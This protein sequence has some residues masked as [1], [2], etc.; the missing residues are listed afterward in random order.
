MFIL[1][2]M[3][4]LALMVI[5]YAQRIF[6]YSYAKFDDPDGNFKA[7]CI[8]DDKSAVDIG[9]VTIGSK[10]KDS[11][12]TQMLTCVELSLPIQ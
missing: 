9:G 11:S 2:Q 10:M 3:C 1:L 8:T 4:I 12:I 5:N 6:F 7:K